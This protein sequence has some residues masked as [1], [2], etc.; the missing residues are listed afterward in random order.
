MRPKRGCIL[1]SY[2]NKTLD[3]RVDCLRSV[4]QRT[5]DTKNVSNIII[6]F[7]YSLAS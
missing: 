2:N 4:K 3:A 6:N 5:V 1:I 7:M